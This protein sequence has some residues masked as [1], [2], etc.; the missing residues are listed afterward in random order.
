[1]RIALLSKIAWVL[2]L[3]LVLF[4]PLSLIDGKIVERRELRDSVARELAETGVG[5]QSVVG[6][7][8]VLPCSERF[9]I[10]EKNER[11][12]TVTRVD[13][14]DCTLRLVATDLRMQGKLVTDVRMRGIY[15]VLFYDTDV[16]VTGHF[17]LPTLPKPPPDVL[18]RTYLAPELRMGI[19]DVR[20]IGTAVQ[21]QFDGRKQLPGPGSRDPVLGHGI[22]AR[23]TGTPGFG[24]QLS[25][26]RHAFRLQLTLAGTSGIDFVPLARSTQV[27]LSGSWPHPS[28]YGRFLPVTRA[29]NDQGFRAQWRVSE[30]AS[31]APGVFLECV[32]SGSSCAHLDRERFGVE[33]VEPVDVYVQ[34]ERA[35]TYGFLFIGLTFV[36]FVLFELIAALRLHGMQYALVGLALAV[37]FLLLFALA[38]HLAFA[39][40]YV[41]AAVACISLI[42]FYVSHLLRSTLRAALFSL[43]LIGLYGA[44]YVL[45]RSEDFAMLLGALLVFAVLAVTMVLTR[46]MDWSRIGEARAQSAESAPTQT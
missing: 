14:R 43:Y 8:L 24:G 13:R 29:V 45:L 38:E 44:L 16:T 17:D 1:M 35:V 36:V 21:L 20:G 37:F 39:H 12:E 25:A 19:A 30:L 22:H 11:F 15:R 40:A 2:L 34:S 42:S 18:E 23:L 31:D 5:H 28:F 26:G 33:L 32:R 27:A 6:P 3:G 4:V 9:Q 46:R 7:V 10:H 41:I